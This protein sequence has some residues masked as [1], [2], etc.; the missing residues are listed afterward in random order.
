[1]LKR[2]RPRCGG[3]VRDGGRTEMDER[4]REASHAVDVL[5]R[6]LESH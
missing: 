4:M 3:S 5:S 1:M 6:S 2:S